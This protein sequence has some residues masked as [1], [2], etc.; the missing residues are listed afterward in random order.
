MLGI[1]L[2]GVRS[3]LMT[4]RELLMRLGWVLA[5]VVRGEEVRRR[6]WKRMLDA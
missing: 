4:K 5:R 6:S 3:D 1:F 2:R